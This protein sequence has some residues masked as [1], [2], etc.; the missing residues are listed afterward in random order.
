MKKLWL[1]TSVLALLVACAI[2]LTW[3]GWLPYPSAVTNLESR[4][5]FGDSFG[6]VNAFLSGCA[7]VGLLVT[8]AYQQRQISSQGAEMER[9]AK[10]DAVAQFEETLYRLL[11]LYQQSVSDV[12]I[13]RSNQTYRGRDALRHCALAA[14]REIKRS[15]ASSLPHDV[16]TRMRKGSA[17]VEDKLLFDH[18]CIQNFMHIEHLALIQRRVISNLVLL[19]MHLE[20]RIPEGIDR[21]HYRRLVSA[22]L[23]HVEVQYIFLVALAFANEEELRALLNEAEILKRDSNPFSLDLHRQ[24][25]LHF[26]NVDPGA[27]VQP[28]TMPLPKSRKR[29]LKRS[30]LLRRVLVDRGLQPDQQTGADV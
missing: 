14:C 7:F 18:L 4:G 2:V 28:R 25:Y 13:T 12:V 30:A 24:M 9:Q 17:T 23:T 27:K 10:R 19:L 5:Q 26:Y 16:K 20:R 3:G 8:I 21:E 11:G 15:G 29:E 22:Q 1:L 6:V